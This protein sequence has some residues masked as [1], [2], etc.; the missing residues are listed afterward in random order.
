[1][2]ALFPKDFIDASQFREIPDTQEVY[3]SQTVDD[4]LVVDLMEAV[5]KVGDGAVDEHLQEIAEMN[6]AG[7]NEYARLYTEKVAIRDIVPQ[8]LTGYITIAIEPARKWGRSAQLD[9]SEKL[10]DLA[11]ESPLL[12]TV[13]AVLRLEKVT[14]DVVVTY[15]TPI[16]LR[17]EYEEVQTG[18]PTR[19]PDRVK[20]GLDTVR[21][22]V[23]S[24]KVN[25]WTL[26]G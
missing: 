17:R 5:E 21:Q 14:T 16:T 4:S 3:V 1:M 24:L 12:V 19:M 15:N 10:A 7:A 23:Q 20:K 9:Q 8:E 11:L 18:D 2:T 6:N 22:L 25:D 13:L 26:F